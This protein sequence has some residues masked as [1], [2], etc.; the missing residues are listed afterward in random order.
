MRSE[1]ENVTR[2]WHGY[3]TGFVGYGMALVPQYGTEAC[4]IPSEGYGTGLVP[5]CI[6]VKQLPFEVLLRIAVSRLSVFWPGAILHN[7]EH[8]FLKKKLHLKTN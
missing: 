6:L 7:F 3:G 8:V 5:Y 4:A 1:I 2:V